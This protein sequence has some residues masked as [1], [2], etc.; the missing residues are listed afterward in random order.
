MNRE[1]AQ[2][3]EKGHNPLFFF[4]FKFNLE[5]CVSFKEGDKA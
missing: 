1:K 4:S 2:F 3:A 5:T